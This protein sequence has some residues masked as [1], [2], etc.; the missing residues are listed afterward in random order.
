MGEMRGHIV[1]TTRGNAYYYESCITHQQL[2]F[3]HLPSYSN[4]IVSIYSNKAIIY[5]RELQEENISIQTLINKDQKLEGW[6]D[7]CERL[8]L[9]LASN[10]SNGKF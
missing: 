5:H 1:H 9:T 10:C 7:T 6:R 2:H 3:N 8:H 4:I